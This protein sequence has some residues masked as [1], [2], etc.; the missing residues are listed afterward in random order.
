M[1]RKPL[2]ILSL[3]GLLLSVGAWGASYLVMG[4]QGKAHIIALHEGG[5]DYTHYTY[6][7][8]VEPYWYLLGFRRFRTHWRIYLFERLDGWGVFIPLWMPSGL[9][10]VFLAMRFVPFAR[11]RRRRKLGLCLK[12]GY[13]LR[14]SEVRCPECGT[15]FTREGTRKS[16]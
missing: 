2:T 7:D 5:I 12:C 4:H 11:W 9:F 10:V 1:P 3:I 15:G 6:D 14:A 16:P 8:R 13:D